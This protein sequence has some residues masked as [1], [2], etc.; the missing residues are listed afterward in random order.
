MKE[1]RYTL[2]SDGSSDRALI[3]ILNWILRQYKVGFALQPA[4]ADLRRIRK[5]IRGLTARIQWALELYPCDI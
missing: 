2:V 5:P 4:W 1:V 3:P